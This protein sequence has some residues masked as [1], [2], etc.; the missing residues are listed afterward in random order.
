MNQDD[1]VG[2]VL[3]AVIFFAFVLLMSGG[4]KNEAPP[5]PDQNKKDELAREVLGGGSIEEIAE[6]EKLNPED[7]EIWKN[8]YLA[9]IL[10]LAKNFEK[11]QNQI[12]LL[13]EDIEWFKAA[14]K[15]HIGDDWEEKTDFANRARIKYK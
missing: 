4:K 13:T 2:M 9:Y 5:E 12:D 10:N 14:C 7:L 8:E 1:M 3:I 11:T 6:R 15:D